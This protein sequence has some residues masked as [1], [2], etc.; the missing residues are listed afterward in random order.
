[1]PGFLLDTNV[2]AEVSRPTPDAGVIR[3]LAAEPAHRLSISVLTIGE[4]QKG[5]S[6]LPDGMKRKRLERW[7]EE[8]VARRFGERLLAVDDVVA[9]E[10]GRLAASGARTGRP[11][12]IVD[13]LLLATAAAHELTLATRDSSGCRGR[14]V[15]VFDPWTGEVHPA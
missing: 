3:W 12:P 6:L 2:V 5:V 8:E 14:G 10:W 13:G 15:E 11:L 1:M 7:L 9:R 4:I